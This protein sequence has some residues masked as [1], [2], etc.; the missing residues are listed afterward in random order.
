MDYRDIL[1]LSHILEDLLDG[2]R[3]G[4][5]ELTPERLNILYEGTDTIEKMVRIIEDSSGEQID[6]KP[7]LDRL[8]S[9]SSGSPKDGQKSFFSS[10]LQKKTGTSL[11]QT[12]LSDLIKDDKPHYK[13]ILAYQ[14]TALALQHGHI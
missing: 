11:S 12:D 1:E 14:M 10:G 5:I 8:I 9:L 6:S 3:N 4:D 7:L 2:I 13:F